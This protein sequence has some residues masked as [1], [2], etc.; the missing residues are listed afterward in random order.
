MNLF[1]SVCEN[2][3]YT[4]LKTD[5]GQHDKNIFAIIRSLRG[6]GVNKIKI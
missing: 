4:H 5:E 2:A 3:S 6:V 1:L